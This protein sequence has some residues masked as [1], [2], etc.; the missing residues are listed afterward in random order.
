VNAKWLSELWRY[1]EL[2]YFLAWRDVKVRYKQAALGAAWAVLQPLLSTVV[3]TFFFANVAGIAT[4]GTPYPLF[5]YSALLLWTYFA[6]VLSQGGQSLVA[7]W[8]LITKVYFPRAALPASNALSGLLDFGVGSV[9]L[10]VLMAYYG[11]QPGWSLLLAPVFLAAL[12]LFTLGVSMLVASLNVWYRDAKYAMAFAIQL[13]LFITPV[14]YPTTTLPERLQPLMALNPLTGIIEG[15]RACVLGSPTPN[16]AVTAASLTL[17]VLVF[18]V[19]LLYFRKSER[20][21]ADVI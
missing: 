12:V 7:N 21:F 18:A 4:D 16:P 3:F 19:G 15:F 6:G 11:V 2:V 10:V 1:R 20:V 14:V 13:G 5:A 8:Q 9:F 17:A